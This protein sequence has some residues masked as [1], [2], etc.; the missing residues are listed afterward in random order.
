ME[1]LLDAIQEGRLFELPENDKTHALQ[2]LAHVIEAF[3]DTPAGTDVVGLVLKR[4]ETANTGLGKGWACPHARV[5]YE[6][7][8]MCVIGWSPSG[9]DYQSFDGK[10]VSIIVMHV[11]PD[12]QRSRYLK[13]ISILAKALSTYQQVEKVREAKNLDDVRLY[14]LDM[15]E[16]TRTAAA[17]DVRARMIT[18]QTKP[19]ALVQPLPELSN[20]IIEP[21]NIIAGP[22]FKPVILCQNPAVADYLDK[23]QDLLEKLEK[24]GFYQNGGWRVLKRAVTVYQ[25]GRTVYDCLAIKI[26]SGTSMNKPS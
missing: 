17:P 14:L 7:D 12:N 23:A 19:A 9:I 10:P 20:M 26:I 18:L 11:V 22:D 15:V 3:P 8:L 4:E 1:T 6:G 5:P 13:E 24:E 2:F 21:V 25:K 16:T